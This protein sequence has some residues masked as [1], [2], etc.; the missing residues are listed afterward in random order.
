MAGLRGAGALPPCRAAPSLAASYSLAAN[1]PTPSIPALS[2]VSFMASGW[3]LAT[4]GGGGG[5]GAESSR[6]VGVAQFDKRH[7]LSGLCGGNSLA[8]MARGGLGGGGGGYTAI[9]RGFGNF[10]GSMVKVGG[11]G[12]NMLGGASGSTTMPS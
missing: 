1:D 9:G 11:Q 12:G 2:C 10:L 3:R 7:R 5:G 4:A 8:R 6:S